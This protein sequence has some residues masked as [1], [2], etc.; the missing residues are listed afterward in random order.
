MP[1]RFD[2]MPT[3]SLP[4]TVG[5]TVAEVT[6]REDT[7]RESEAENAE[8]LRQMQLDEVNRRLEQNAHLPASIA[9]ATRDVS[10][11]VP[12]HANGHELF[13]KL[14]EHYTRTGQLS[15][16]GR[17]FEELRGLARQISCG[18]KQPKSFI[19]WC[20]DLCNRN[21]FGN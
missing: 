3:L 21:V 16:T 10:I 2:G 18:K 15:K 6:P 12:G 5:G 17:Y 11:D 19:N 13:R 4:D 14:S 7:P 20:L 8:R 9:S 1:A